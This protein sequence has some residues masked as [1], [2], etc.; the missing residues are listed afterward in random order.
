MLKSLPPMLQ[1]DVCQCHQC[2][3][4]C[5]D[6]HTAQNKENICQNERREFL[7]NPHKWAIIV[8]K[9]GLPLHILLIFQ[10][11]FHWRT[12]STIQFYPQQFCKGGA[13]VH[14]FAARQHHIRLSDLNAF[15]TL[16]APHAK[17]KEAVY[18]DVPGEIDILIATDCI[19]EGQNLQDCDA[20][21]NYD[22]HWNPVRIIQRFGRIDRIGSQSAT[23]QLV[24]FWPTKDLDEYIDLVQRV[25][26]RMVLLDVSATGE[27]NLIDE[28]AQ[29]MNDLAYRKRQ[30]EQLKNQVIDLEDISGGISITDLTFNDFKAD[31]REALQAQEPTLAA[32]PRGLYALAAIP[33][34]MADEL[35]P[36]AVFVLESVTPQ[37]GAKDNP[38]A[39]YVLVYI[40]D[41]G[42][43]R[44][45]FL[46]AKQ[47]LD[48]M[49]RLCQGQTSPD[50]ALV[51]SFAQETGH[52]RS[53]EKY[54]TLLQEALASLS[55]K[56]QELGM[57]SL[58]TRG[59]AALAGPRTS[60]HYD[61]VCYLILRRRDGYA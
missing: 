21:V 7:T 5:D 18:P 27:E 6:R 25:R 9:T 23:V 13:L 14:D 1:G 30:M 2:G 40:T 32:L 36:G 50:A 31:L 58:F 17:H 42:T 35:A 10:Q 3:T 38:L 24:N 60:E 33:D 61:V 8:K 55:K 29:G 51:A 54:A 49:K 11:R 56:H 44:L 48:I 19:S 20:L 37:A 12:L 59:A 39:P 26:G 28:K 4:Y 53:M 43:V 16:F 52:G 46:Q 57:R 45:N 41:D 15:L 22:I 34:D 47:I